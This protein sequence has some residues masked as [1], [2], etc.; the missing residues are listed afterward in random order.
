VVARGGG[1]RWRRGQA[2]AEPE[3]G[4]D[5]CGPPVNWARIGANA[6]RGEAFPREGGCNRAGRHR[7]VADW[8]ERVRPSGERESSR[9]GKEKG[10][11][12]RLAQKSELGPIQV[13]KPF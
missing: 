7:R 13:I 9:Q 3:E 8:A 10:S 6:A 5:R 12:P 2:R 4:N 1:M 11:G